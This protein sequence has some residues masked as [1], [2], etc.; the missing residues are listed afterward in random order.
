MMPAGE[1]AVVFVAT[2]HDTHRSKHAVPAVANGRVFV[3]GQ[4][5]VAVFGLR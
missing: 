1:H 2:E 3:G 5:S 4:N